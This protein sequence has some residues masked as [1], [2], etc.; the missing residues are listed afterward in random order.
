MRRKK[1]YILYDNST[2]LPV[3]LGTIEVCAKATGSSP[4]SLIESNSKLKSGLIPSV[5]YQLFDLD[6]VINGYYL[7]ES[8]RVE[9]QMSQ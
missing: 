4:R 7:E 2:T 8:E 9:E 6:K 1:E 3:A 5:R